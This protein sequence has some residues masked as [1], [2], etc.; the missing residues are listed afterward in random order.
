M[1]DSKIIELFFERSEQAITELSEKYGAV[2]MKTARNILGSKSDAEECVNDTYLAVWN[3]V[4]PQKPNPLLTYLCKIV[5]NISLKKYH[6]NTAQKR[7][8]VYD[9]ALDEIEDYIPSPSNVEDELNAKLLS[10]Q[11]ADFLY[12]LDK[13][14]RVMFVRR[15]WYSDSVS[16]IA[17]AFGT[18]AHNVS[19]RLHRIRKE[20]K[21]YLTSKGEI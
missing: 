4:P 8:T 11:I 5:R 6:S 9:A 15:Y 17:A 21:N 10:Q 1:D 3:T 2:C 16:D 7:N 12:T 14:N 20:L 13:D 19:A 18:S